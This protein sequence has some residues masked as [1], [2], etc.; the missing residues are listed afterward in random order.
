MFRNLKKLCKSQWDRTA[1]VVLAVSGLVALLI[2][3]AGVSSTVFTHKQM[4]YVVSGGLLGV[5]LVSAAGALWRSADLRDAWR[6]LD[7]LEQLVTDLVPAS[8]L[9]DL[10]DTTAPATA[11]HNG[12]RVSSPASA[13]G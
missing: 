4:P 3:W 10:G 9:V 11:S 2:A 12:V 6:K 7:R 5:C 13:E 1:A 8:P